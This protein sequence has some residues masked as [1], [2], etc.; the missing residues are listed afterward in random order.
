MDR[1]AADGTVI[2][3]LERA[4]VPRRSSAKALLT[5][6]LPKRPKKAGRKPN[7]RG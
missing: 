2:V 7:P 3:T 6:R 4:A 1:L 5:A